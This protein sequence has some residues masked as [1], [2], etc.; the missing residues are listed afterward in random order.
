M[1]R[2]LISCLTVFLASGVVAYAQQGGGG[3]GGALI[4]EQAP[5]DRAVPILK[6]TLAT[7]LKDMDA[8]KLST[9]RMIEGGK[10]NVNI[11]RITNAETA[12][13]HPNT[14]DLWVVLEGSGT[15]TTGGKLENGKIIGG[16][17]NPLKVGDVY[18]VPAG[19]PHGVSGVNGNITWLNVRWDVD[20]PADA[21]L[22]AGNVPGRT[23]AR[24]AAA[25][26]AGGGRGGMAPLEYAPTDRAI[27][28][29]KEKLDAYRKDM[30]AK[31]LPVL[32]MI[33]GGH[34]NVNIRRITAPS[35]EF[36][37]ITIDT[38]VVL[39]GQGTVNTA[40]KK[41]DDKRIEGTGASTPAKVGDVFFIPA[42]LNHGFSA[43]NDAVAWLN[44]R[45]DVNW[46]K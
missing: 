46:A 32:R 19:V 23:P 27:Y 15:M 33:E 24:P 36:H 2:A 21:P 42:N 35:A 40:F 34:F 10:F 11:R 16:E 45:W 13:V 9:L 20:W 44:I 31:N 17:S 41:Q 28:I 30:A 3:R 25:P 5:T 7:Y 38:W 39:E 43:V 37:P 18:F 1:Q 8:K 4:L 26:A 29:P 12:L 6:E 22:G 14:I